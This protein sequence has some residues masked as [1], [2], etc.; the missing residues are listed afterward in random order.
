[1]AAI[2]TFDWF[3]ERFYPAPDEETAGFIRGE[4]QY[5]LSIRNENERLRYIET[6]MQQVRDERT[7]QGAEH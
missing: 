6:L 4:R 5:I 1:M 2:D 7:A 3:V